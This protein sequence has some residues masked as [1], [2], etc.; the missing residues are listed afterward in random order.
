MK[1]RINLRG[2]VIVLIVSLFFT[3]LSISCTWED[4]KE[5]ADDLWNC[6]LFPKGKC[7][8]SGPDCVD[9]EIQYRDD[10]E[11]WWPDPGDFPVLDTGI[12]VEERCDQTYLKVWSAGGTDRV[13][14]VTAC[15][16]Y[17]GDVVAQGVPLCVPNGGY[18]GLYLYIPLN[19]ADLDTGMYSISTYY[20][21]NIADA[22]D[23]KKS[24]FRSVDIG[25][26][27]IP[28]LLVDTLMAQP[29]MP[30]GGTSLFQNDYLCMIADDYME[31]TVVH[32]SS[33]TDIEIVSGTATHPNVTWS[34]FGADVSA[35]ELILQ[36]GR[37]I[38]RA[39][40]PVSAGDCYL[41]ATDPTWGGGCADT[42]EIEITS[43]SGL[44]C[45]TE[46][47]AWAGVGK[48][49]SQG[50]T[51]VGV[52]ADIYTRYGAKLCGLPDDTINASFS[53]VWIEAAY[54][55]VAGYN[56]WF[57][58]Q[59]GY[60]KLRLENYPQGK[61]MRYI[62]VEYG[63]SLTVAREYDFENGGMTPPGDGEKH[64]F[65]LE[66][67]PATGAFTALY[68]S[69]DALVTDSVPAWQGLLFEQVKF[70]AEI[71]NIEDDMAG[72]A[73]DKCYIYNLRTK[74]QNGSYGAVTL[75]GAQREF[76][77]TTEW[78]VEAN[79]ALDTIAIWDVFPR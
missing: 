7:K 63:D 12:I 5:A 17:H 28:Q 22:S 11:Y 37:V 56:D 62:E 45:C 44:N 72:T 23:R 38:L 3:T 75:L 4:I 27:H 48:T 60:G 21:D 19:G 64:Q 76:S 33:P 73:S 1:T 77:D 53:L 74:P 41:V 31:L 54:D 24:F 59:T 43:C 49:N 25:R 29:R 40:H 69:V 42:L 71:L 61:M 39:D 36:S 46:T 6:I 8:C 66:L 32:H 47:H 30:I 65:T 35:V 14:Y 26:A 20:S 70:S 57:W 52:Q 13:T 15:L 9:G 34:L 79:S 10:D 18:Q 16:E 50:K 55:T 78:M 68:D 2:S 67:D 58:G 51:L